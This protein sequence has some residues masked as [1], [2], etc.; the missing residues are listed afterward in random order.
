MPDVTSPP[1]PALCPLLLHPSAFIHTQPGQSLGTVA[2][3]RPPSAPGSDIN[4]N[5]V[6]SR[7]VPDI[8]KRRDPSCRR[9]KNSLPPFM[10]GGCVQPVVMGTFSCSYAKSLQGLGRL[11]QLQQPGTFT[12]VLDHLWRHRPQFWVSV[13]SKT[14][15]CEH[16]LQGTKSSSRRKESLPCLRVKSCD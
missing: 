4:L 11:S 6:R 15:L 2:S 10:R 7:Q 16:L 13:G 14:R 8:N 1:P 9:W 12:S 5:A 3:C